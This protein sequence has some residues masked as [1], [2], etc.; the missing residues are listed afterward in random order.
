MDSRQCQYF[1]VVR[2]EISGKEVHRST[3]NRGVSAVKGPG[4]T[5]G[6][7]E[8][9]FSA[10]NAMLLTFRRLIIDQDKLT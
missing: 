4:T 6:V 7:I 10:I 5:V 3:S 8:E 2:W 1:V 9:C